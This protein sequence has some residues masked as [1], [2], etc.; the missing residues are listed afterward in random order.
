MKDT[1]NTIYFKEKFRVMLN[2]NT[3]DMFIICDYDKRDYSVNMNIQHYHDFYEIFI[4]LE[5]NVAHLV[6]SRYYPLMQND[7]VLLKP[8]CLHMSVY[9]KINEAQKRL[10]IDFRLADGIPGLEH[11]MK[12]FF[13]LFEK[14]IPIFRFPPDITAEIIGVLNEIFVIGKTKSA[15]WEV[16]LY[17]KF[18]EF[19]WVIYKN[20]PYNCFNEKRNIESKEQKIYY[21]QDYI[22][23]HYREDLSLEKISDEFAISPYYL[24]HIFKEMTGLNFVNYVQ[25]I[26]VRN[27]LQLLTYSDES[28][29][30]IIENCGFTSTSQ[31]NRVFHQFLGISPSSFRRSQEEKKLIYMGYMNPESEE[32]AP[33]N[34]QSK[35][36]IRQRM[37]IEKEGEFRVGMIAHDLGVMIPSVLKERL[38]LLSLDTVQLS[39]P[40]SFPGKKDYLSL[41]KRNIVEIKEQNYDISVLASYVDLASPDDEVW[42][43]GIE[44]VKKAIEVASQLNARVVASGT[45]ECRSEEEREKRFRRLGDALSLILP[46]AEEYNVPFA[47]EPSVRETINSLYMITRLYDRFPDSSLKLIFDPVELIAD[48][49]ANNTFDFFDNMIEKFGDR[50][51]AMHIKDV[52]NREE[53][54]LG[55][56]IMA[57]IYPHIAKVL[58]MN[59]P[60]IRE[61]SLPSSLEADLLFIRRLFK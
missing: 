42:N 1:H 48:D 33:A 61:N 9:P 51:A 37:K 19:L 27:V 17:S 11:E 22:N 59:I 57:K 13:S 50:F 23:T 25:S 14:E 55:S 60:L 38:Q 53:V 30:S 10:I 36:N 8:G 34:F 5:T 31:F 35:L 4:P 2:R 20:T 18:I 6:D 44:N 3:D 54:P 32:K 49:G 39:I 28:I 46:A 15:L 29:S 24:S 47:V 56:G 40:E 26:R 16:A 7:I 58:R 21:I 41:T 12:R 43:H 52:I 45:G